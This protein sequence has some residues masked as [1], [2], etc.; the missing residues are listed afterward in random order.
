ME[1]LGFRRLGGSALY[2]PEAHVSEP[3]EARLGLFLDT[4]GSD[5]VHLS[6]VW[7]RCVLVVWHP[8]I[9]TSTF[10]A[11]L[12]GLL[13]DLE[14]GRARIAFFTADQDR[15]VVVET[16][17]DGFTV[18][19]SVTI[20]LDGESYE[21]RTASRAR[22]RV[23]DEQVII[24]PPEARF[25]RWVF[26]R[27]GGGTVRLPIQGPLTL[28]LAGPERATFKF[29]LPLDDQGLDDLGV[30]LRYSQAGEWFRGGGGRL[31]ATIRGHRLPI[32][33][34]PDAEPIPFE[35]RF[36]AL[37]PL[38]PERT[39]L[40]FET[41]RAV[42][43][44]FETVLGHGL[45]LTPL[46]GAALVL[47]HGVE[48]IAE[49]LAILDSRSYLTPDGSFTM[50]LEPDPARPISVDVGAGAGADLQQ[51]VT[52]ISTSEFV[53]F[54]PGDRLTFHAKRPATDP[55]GLVPPSEDQRE[56]AVPA[57]ELHDLTTTAWVSIAAPDSELEGRASSHSLH[58][59]P[60]EMTLY[61]DAERHEATA[62]RSMVF[63]SQNRPGI[64]NRP[65]PMAPFLGLTR[66][67]D[68]PAATLKLESELIS[69]ARQKELPILEFEQTRT[70]VRTG[71]E[72]RFTPQGFPVEL[73]DGRWRRL[74][75]ANTP[76]GDFG[77][78]E[79]D[80]AFTRV[81]VRDRVCLVISR[82][83]EALGTLIDDLEVAG[84]GCRFKKASRI[85]H[86]RAKGFRPPH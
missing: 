71:R 51:L 69:A 58:S 31:S 80:P 3:N 74:V 32:F 2:L 28:P 61:G 5:P 4:P 66:L 47:D 83:P 29:D 63:T 60:E 50:G 67:T 41:G 40:S 43:S 86:R 35:V 27:E 45:T 8:E 42:M 79:V 36:D 1:R 16:E 9:D 25:H 73:E 53:P 20:G 13:S 18:T 22:I 68:D 19:S 12:P 55:R 77:F 85:P 62:P 38:D 59:Q 24:E 39:R 76:L 82:L 44:E 21:L 7:G 52:G 26:V 10:F 81:L 15:R 49:D 56:S 54:R 84:W 30:H 37:S 70:A 23:D 65:F 72:Q 14:S 48:R 57:I 6:E 46:P 17:A 64:G 11:R 33:R 75:M 34:Q 78:D